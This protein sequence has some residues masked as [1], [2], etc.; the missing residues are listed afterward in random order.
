MA[1][2][3]L[4]SRVVYTDGDGFPKLAEVVGT[5]DSVQE[6]GKA[7]RPDKNAAHLLIK[8]PTG[9]LTELFTAPCSSDR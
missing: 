8:S 3:K 2:F 5:R 7:T 4:G 1:N 9:S 6:N